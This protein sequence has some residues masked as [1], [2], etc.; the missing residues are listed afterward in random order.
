MGL[1]TGS[2]LAEWKIPPIYRSAIQKCDGPIED[3]DFL[4]PPNNASSEFVGNGKVV[5]I[6]WI[7]GSG[8][9]KIVE[10]W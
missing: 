5:V 4:C 2:I 6:S 10:C 3:K 8:W 7:F 9:V 1:L